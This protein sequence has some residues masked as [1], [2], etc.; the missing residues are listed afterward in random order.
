MATCAR[1]SGSDVVNGAERCVTDG[2]GTDGTI[3]T[4]AG[5]TGTAGTAGTAG[6]TT[7][8]AGAMPGGSGTNGPGRPPAVTVLVASASVPVASVAWAT[9]CSARPCTTAGGEIP[10]VAADTRTTRSAPLTA[11]ARV[12]DCDGGRGSRGDPSVSGWSILRSLIP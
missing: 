9:V 3:V 7:C 11:P 10:P 1:W 6:S 8:G 5:T 4:G 12:R 2:S